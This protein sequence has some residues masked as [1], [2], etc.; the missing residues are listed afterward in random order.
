MAKN[1]GLK[2]R[3]MMAQMIVH[4]RLDEVI[5]VVVIGVLAQL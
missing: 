2:L 4:K 3:R 1:L 5:A